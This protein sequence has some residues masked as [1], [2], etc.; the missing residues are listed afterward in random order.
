MP[1]RVIRGEINRS[2]SLARVS[3]QAETLLLWMGMPPSIPGLYIVTSNRLRGGEI[4]IKAGRALDVAKRVR[5]HAIDIREHARWARVEARCEL[6]AVATFPPS[7]SQLK[8]AETALLRR[9]SSVAERPETRDRR[10][11][12]WFW[13]EPARLFEIIWGHSCRTAF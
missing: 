3:M 1:S 6:L 5:D 2:D 8:K 7:V 12:E 13:I 10:G 4:E 9:I 11:R